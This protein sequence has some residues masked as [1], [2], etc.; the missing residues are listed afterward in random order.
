MKTAISVLIDYR[1]VALTSTREWFWQVNDGEAVPWH[2]VYDTV[3]L[4][5]MLELIRMDLNDDHG[6]I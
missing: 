1:P 2:I 5:P 6:I 4:Q 3:L